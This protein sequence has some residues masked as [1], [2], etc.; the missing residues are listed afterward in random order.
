MI[1]GAVVIGNW[2]ISKFKI[3]QFN[4]VK[5]I[6]I[7]AIIIVLL[8]FIILNNVYI[9]LLLFILHVI[10]NIIILNVNLSYLHSDVIQDNKNRNAIIS[11]FNFFSSCIVGILLTVQ[12]YFSNIYGI[13]NTWLIFSI[14]GAVIYLVMYKQMLKFKGGSNDKL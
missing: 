1:V 9:A 5:F 11:T 14:V 7:D 8:K 13:T 2:I 10:V 12:G 6:V 3:S 4:I